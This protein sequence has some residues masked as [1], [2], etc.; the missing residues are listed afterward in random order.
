MGPSHWQWLQDSSAVLEFVAA[1]LA[2][3]GAGMSFARSARKSLKDQ[4]RREQADDRGDGTAAPARTSEGD[5]NS[6]PLRHVR[7]RGRPGR[8]RR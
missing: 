7:A 5:E 1:L 6:A 3:A 4:R 8:L 2:A